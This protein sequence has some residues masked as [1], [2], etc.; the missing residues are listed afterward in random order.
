[1]IFRIF[2][3]FTIIFLL[4][5]CKPEDGWC[6]LEKY[7]GSEDFECSQMDSDFSC[8]GQSILESFTDRTFHYRK[9][10]VSDGSAFETVMERPQY[11][12]E[13]LTFISM[14]SCFLAPSIGGIDCKSW[15]EFEF[16]TQENFTVTASSRLDDKTVSACNPRY[17]EVELEEQTLSG[18]K[19]NSEF[20]LNDTV[21][22]NGSE[23]K[24][25]HYFISEDL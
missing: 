6:E 15:S 21:I 13:T 8:T 22:K 10:E 11:I 9:T 24:V 7:S 14:D 12:P 3:V 18:I 2:T 19:L 1:M 17:I 16:S 23:I 25:R 4:S 20:Y 5:G